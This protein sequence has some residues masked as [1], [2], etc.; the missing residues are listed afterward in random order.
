MIQL[1]EEAERDLTNG[2][3]KIF[4]HH[5]MAVNCF[6]FSLELNVCQPSIVVNALTT[7]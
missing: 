7:K 5:F 2:W 3:N 6:G 4:M 1:N